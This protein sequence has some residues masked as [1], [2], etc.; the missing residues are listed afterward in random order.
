VLAVHC[1]KTEWVPVPDSGIVNGELVALLVMVTLAPLTAPG[2]VGANVTSRV[3]DW[4]GVSTVPLEMP[5]ALNSAPVTVTAEIVMS[6]LPLF[7]TDVGRRLLLPSG[8]LPKGRF[9]GLALSVNVAAVP[10]PD[11]LITRGDG[12]PLVVSVMLPLAAAAEDGVNTA[13]NVV[14]PPAGIVVD[15]DR[16]DWLKPGPDTLICEKESVMLPVF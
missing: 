8:T 15:A 16:P 5:L 3:T 11:K 10:V 13:S 2:V 9:G 6:E 12:A 1:S 4:P 14:L 7:I